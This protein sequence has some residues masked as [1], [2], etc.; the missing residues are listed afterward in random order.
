MKKSL[1]IYLML[2]VILILVPVTFISM[3]TVNKELR[4]TIL[5]AVYD[6]P[7]VLKQTALLYLSKTER[8]HHEHAH[9]YTLLSFTL[10]NYNQAGVDKNAILG[11][12]NLLIKRG[13][14]INAYNSKGT[15]ALH[16]AVLINK[17]DL[18]RFLIE[19]GAD[20]NKPIADPGESRVNQLTPLEFAEW[21]QTHSSE[22]GDWRDSIALLRQ[23]AGS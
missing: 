21:L 17:P 14:D 10:S 13:I 7:D 6:G 11:L 1:F 8:I 22:R 15:T 16:E 9:P 19:R 18:L 2:I 20:L 3:Y 12:I 4:Y 5:D 23:Y